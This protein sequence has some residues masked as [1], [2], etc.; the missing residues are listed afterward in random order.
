[1]NKWLQLIRFYSHLCDFPARKRKNE[2]RKAK[3]V[4]KSQRI[5]SKAFTLIRFLCQWKKNFKN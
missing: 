3:L 4:N 5:T 1:M 2:I